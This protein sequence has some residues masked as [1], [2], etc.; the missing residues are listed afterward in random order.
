MSRSRAVFLSMIT[1]ALALVPQAQA[2]TIPFTSDNGPDGWIYDST[3]TKVG[4]FFFNISNIPGSTKS[5]G[6]YI[7]WQWDQ[8]VNLIGFHV[9]F[10]NNFPVGPLSIT[11]TQFQNNYDFSKSTDWACTFTAMTDT[12]NATSS[13]DEVTNAQW[14]ASTTY[15]SDIVQGTLGFSGYLLTSDTR[16]A[17]A[18][19]EPGS[20]VLAA[21][22]IA[23]GGYIRRKKTTAPP[24]GV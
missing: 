13:A 12:C 4:V 21:S 10:G 9:D 20:I 3:H 15:F 5:N 17:P 1:C 22:G 8:P 23:L 11:S 18:V 19:P 2:G 24:R 6:I 16:S 14:W 7:Y